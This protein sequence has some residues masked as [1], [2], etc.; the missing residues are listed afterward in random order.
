MFQ[1]EQEP[2]LCIFKHDTKIEKDIIENLNRLKKRRK[3]NKII[4]NLE[5][6]KIIAHYIDKI[7]LKLDE[8]DR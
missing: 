3:E 4:D 1:M 7:V 6:L 2:E 8:I 5:K